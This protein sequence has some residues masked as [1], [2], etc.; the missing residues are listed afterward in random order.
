MAIK[1]STGDSLKQRI[2]TWFPDSSLMSPELL[3]ASILVAQE[4]ADSFHLLE[5]LYATIQAVGRWEPW[6]TIRYSEGIL[7]SEPAPPDGDQIYFASRV[8]VTPTC[9]MLFH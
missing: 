7:D 4:F 3:T 6:Q 8:D 2:A 1:L 5:S 9:S